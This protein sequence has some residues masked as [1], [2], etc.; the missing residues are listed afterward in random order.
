[1]PLSKRASQGL[2]ATSGSILCAKVG[3]PLTLWLALS[4]GHR[5][6]PRTYGAVVP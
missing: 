6:D 5:Y 1:M 3:N 2:P 4:E